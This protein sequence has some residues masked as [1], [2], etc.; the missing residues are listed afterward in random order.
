MKTLTPHDALIA[1][2]I[3]M[4]AAD[5]K[6]AECELARMELIVRNFPVFRDYDTSRVRYVSETCCTYLFNEKLHSLLDSVAAALPQ[7]LHE[8]A[9]ALAVEV[10]VADSQVSNE[11]IYLLELLRETLNLD[12]QF[13]SAMQWSARVRH[14][15][16]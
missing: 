1:V 12:K 15:T 10:A 2:M 13:A 4:S 5:G 3:A 8:T 14:Q 9:Y 7:K 11:E 16:L 6:V